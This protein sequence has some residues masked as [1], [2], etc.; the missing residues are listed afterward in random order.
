M[1][2]PIIHCHGERRLFCV[3]AVRAA[4]TYRCVAGACRIIGNLE[5]RSAGG[6]FRARPRRPGGLAAACG[7]PKSRVRRFCG[8]LRSS[9]TA[10]EA[11]CKTNPKGLSGSTTGHCI[12]TRSQRRRNVAFLIVLIAIAVAVFSTGIWHVAEETSAGASRRA[13]P[14]AAS[15]G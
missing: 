3:P 14:A 8:S 9:R 6:S 11:L 10:I 13:V 12:V 1:R 15:E 4:L 5:V 2:I 7:C